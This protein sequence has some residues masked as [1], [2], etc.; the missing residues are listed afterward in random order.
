ML[1]AETKWFGNAVYYVDNSVVLTTGQPMSPVGQPKQRGEGVAIVLT[2]PALD[3]WKA[4]GREWTAWSSRVV[5]ASSTI[6]KKS[7]SKLPAMHQHLLLAEQRRTSSL[8]T[9]SKFWTRYQ[10]GNSMSYWET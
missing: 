3:T 5:R 10:I 1:V 9:S 6:G 7:L 2:G 8:M 4:G